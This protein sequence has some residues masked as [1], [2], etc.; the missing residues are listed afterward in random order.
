ML[1]L[2]LLVLLLNN[3]TSCCCRNFWY[4]S[5]CLR[6]IG[7]RWIALVPA[8]FPL[9]PSLRGWGISV[10]T[11]H[12]PVYL[13]SDPVSPACCPICP[14]VLNKKTQWFRLIVMSLL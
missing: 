13:S 7:E 6:Q 3:N 11:L 12:I 4:A 8:V 1:L 9:H 2:L 10:V 5:R 14:F